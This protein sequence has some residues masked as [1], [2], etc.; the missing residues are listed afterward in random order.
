MSLAAAACVMVIVGLAFVRSPPDA[1]APRGDVIAAADLFDTPDLRSVAGGRAL[2]KANLQLA[3][4]S[5]AQIRRALEPD[6]DSLRTEEPRVG[7]ECVSTCTSRWLP[8]L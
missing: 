8:Y 6:P 3:R 2:V 1:S 7:K 5:E 4:N